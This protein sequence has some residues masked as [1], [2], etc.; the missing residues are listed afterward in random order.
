MEM[1]GAKDQKKYKKNLIIKIMKKCLK[2]INCLQFAL[3]MLFYSC[4]EQEKSLLP[5]EKENTPTTI[6]RQQLLIT[7][8]WVDHTVLPEGC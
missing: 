2:P 8:P 5:K 6:S 3:L 4:N 7:I 1:V